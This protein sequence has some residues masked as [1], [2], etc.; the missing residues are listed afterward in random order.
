MK[1][2]FVNG[3]FDVLHAGHLDLLNYAKSQGDF[4]MVALDS[5]KRVQEKKGKDRPFNNQYNRLTLMENL[6]AVDA[7]ALFDS[8]DGLRK[9]IKDYEPDLMIIGDDYIDKEII[10][11]E[12]SKFFQFYPRTNG[13]STSKTI[14][15][16]INRR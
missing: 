11:V 4:L 7:V 10:G 5:D 14:Q 8:D 2:V 1:K 9:I 16:F 3:T 13:E 6:K 12:H 15:N